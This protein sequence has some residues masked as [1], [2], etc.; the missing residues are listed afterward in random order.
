MPFWM[1]VWHN[2]GLELYQCVLHTSD[3][4]YDILCGELF[5]T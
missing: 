4:M 2:N 3:V 5:T 1:I